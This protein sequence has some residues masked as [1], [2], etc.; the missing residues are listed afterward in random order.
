[1]KNKLKRLQLATRNYKKKGILFTAVFAATLIGLSILI[2]K[3]NIHADPGEPEVITEAIAYVAAPVAHSLPSHE[4]HAADE[5]RYTVTFQEWSEGTHVL[6]DDEAFEAGKDYTLRVIFTAR[7]G[8][9]ISDEATVYHIND[10]DT[11][12]WG[13]D[14]FRQ[15]HFLNTPSPEDI[16]PV[17]DIT[18]DLNG[19]NVSGESIINEHSV[20]VGMQL[21][22]D[23]LMDRLGVISPSGQVLNYITV[24]DEAFNV[25]D[26]LFLDR[27]ITIKYFWRED[28]ETTYTITFDPNGGTPTENYQVPNEV[29]A[30]QTFVFN[31]PDEDQVIPPE[32]QEFD[33]FEVNGV[34]LENGSVFTINQNSSFKLLWRERQSGGFNRDDYTTIEIGGGATSITEA[35]GDDESVTLTYE[36]GTLIV[37]GT[38]LYSD[39]TPNS[40]GNY[41][42]YA[43]G[44]VSITAVANENYT[45]SLFEQGNRLDSLAKEYENLAPGGFERID[46]EFTEQGGDNPEPGQNYEDITFNLHWVDTFV[47]VWINDR[48]VV[49]ESQDYTAHEFVYNNEV[50]ENAGFTDPGQTNVIRLQN[51]FGDLAV[52]EFTINDTVYNEENENVTI[53]DEGWSIVVPGASVYNI[54]GA[55]DSSIAVPRTIIWANVDADHD[56][57]EF[58]EDML[59]EHGR[60]RVVAIYDDEI[61]VSDGVDVDE[62]T[63]MGWVEVTPGNQV[64]F[65]FVPEYGYQ[66]TSVEANGLPLEP[67]DTMNQYVFE[68]PDTNVHFSATFTPVEDVVEANS[69]RVTSGSIVLNGGLAGG[70]AQLTVNDIELSA[71]KIAGFENAAGDYTISSYLDIDLYNI[72][73][74]ANAGDDEVWSNK[75]DELDEE[76]TI[77]IQLAEGIDASSIVIVHNIHD[78]E[79]Y[80]IIEIDSYDPETNTITFK[81][82][83]FSS[84]AIASADTV[85]E[86]EPEQEESTASPDTGAMTAEKSLVATTILGTLLV[87]LTLASLVACYIKK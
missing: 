51:R 17:F 76:A 33:A 16:E 70:S 25:G 65:E 3:L 66:L 4:V 5:S 1:M 12:S 75:I 20:S 69:A 39:T 72:F 57:D 28:T 68:M 9:V 79:E 73:H 52:T 48:G 86:E 11:S 14:G 37:T 60:A 2:P 74:K 10:L 43:V 45:A 87:S 40:N 26:G 54:S 27:N 22:Y 15:A 59:L 77:T 36:H 32:N 50:V 44:D 46:A 47:N 56:A 81:A 80:E 29:P 31:A 8:Y 49:D 23:Y 63:G 7:E 85:P 42:V 34:R 55:G 38:N 6:E 18:L 78:G 13:G 67:Q 62:A 21:S 58:A 30:G 19:G 82:K 61:I 84:Y 71:D 24:N 64:V 83:S 41:E 35:D 53:N